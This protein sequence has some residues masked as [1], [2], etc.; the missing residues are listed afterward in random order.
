MKVLRRL[1]LVVLALAVGYPA[2][3]AFQIWDQSHND[4]VHSAD[5]IVVLGAAQ[6][7]GKPSPVFKARLDQAA[8]LYDEGLSETVVVTGGKQP[9]DSFTEADAGEAYLAEAH[10]IPSDRILAESEG[11]TTFE[12]LQGVRAIAREQG[13]ESVLL[14][15]D[16]LHSKRIKTIALDLGF[17]RAYASPASYAELDR[18]RATKARELVHEVGS[19]LAY[20]WLQR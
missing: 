12:S 16:P 10:G 1:V 9:G 19:L 11:R 5:A 15:S 13:M 7:N 14:V 6:Y 8:Y 4:E 2:L 20:R 3:L 17:A 18:S